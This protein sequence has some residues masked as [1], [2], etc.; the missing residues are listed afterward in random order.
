MSHLSRELAE[1]KICIRILEGQG[2]D[3]QDGGLPACSSWL[4]ERRMKDG[5][6]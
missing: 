1:T 6:A 5:V 4:R 2:R 3:R